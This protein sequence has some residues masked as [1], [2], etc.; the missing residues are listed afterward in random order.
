MF[1]P[2]NLKSL[3]A[4]TAGS[5]A[6][7]QAYYDTKIKQA[8]EKAGGENVS[9]L[10]AQLS[11]EYDSYKENGGSLG[12]EAWVKYRASDAYFEDS[13]KKQCEAVFGAFD[14]NLEREVIGSLKILNEKIERIEAAVQSKNFSKNIFEDIFIILRGANSFD[15]KYANT[16]SLIKALK[17]QD[18]WKK[19]ANIWERYGVCS[20]AAIESR[21][22]L[23]DTVEK[24]MNEK[25]SK[26]PNLGIK[27]ATW[28]I[29]QFSPGTKIY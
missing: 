21:R 25:S 7:N 3:F 2:Y 4:W 23:W 6:G 20:V 13:K 9:A 16:I 5:L 8:R 28:E 15:A 26:M 11:K 24:E 27:L 17:N 14:P 1:R 12:L 22:D 10:A 18:L 29:A 19:Y